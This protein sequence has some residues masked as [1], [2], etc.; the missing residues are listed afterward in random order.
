MSAILASLL[1]ILFSISNAFASEDVELS[2]KQKQSLGIATASLPPKSSGELAGI[3]AQVVIP[4]NQLF[5]V[6]TPL[7]AMVEQTLVDVGDRVRKGQPLARLQSPALAEA[8]R[9]FLQASTQEQLAKG[10]LNRDEQLWKEGIIAE[11]RLFSARSLY[12]EASAALA[13][14]RHM[15]L[16]AG[17]TTDNIAGLKSGENLGSVLTIRSPIDGVILEKSVSAGQRLES[18]TPLFNVARLQPLGLEM[19]LPLASSHVIRMGAV[20]RI[21]AYSAQGKITAI[22]QSL[23]DSN[24]TILLRALI[25]KGTKNLR[26]GQFVEVSIATSFSSRTQWNVPNTALARIGGKVIIFVETTKGFHAV[27]VIVLHEGEKSTLLT[28]KLGGDE[29]IAIHGVSTLK[30]SLMGIGGGE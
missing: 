13:E 30:A 17:M 9:G 24:Q 6:S 28:A 16:L 11:S 7:S 29:K 23:S 27:S 12:I 26:A 5:V 8:Q 14:K 4:A 3:P 1:L 19:Q 22:G 25:N 20:V 2:P 21:P 15:L 18:A 10:T